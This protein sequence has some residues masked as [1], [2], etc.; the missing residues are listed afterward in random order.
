MGKVHWEK[1]VKKVSRF[2]I[3]TGTFNC[4][5]DPRYVFEDVTKGFKESFLVSVAYNKVSCVGNHIV[6]FVMY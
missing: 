3:R 6:N 2:G 5:S 4:S 1:M